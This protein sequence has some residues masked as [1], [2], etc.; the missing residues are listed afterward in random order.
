MKLTTLQR[1]K[2]EAIRFLEF[3]D[4]AE[5]QNGWYGRINP[6]GFLSLGGV[7]E[8]PCKY[9]AAA[10]RASMDLSRALADLRQGR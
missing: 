9:V 8:A 10:K 4:T 2:N 3:A 5:K 1:A 6:D 7:A